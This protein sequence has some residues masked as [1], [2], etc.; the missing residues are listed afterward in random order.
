MKPDSDSG[1]N[2]CQ[3][4]VRVKTEIMNCKRGNVKA[5]KHDILTD[6]AESALPLCIHGGD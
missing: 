4:G 1:N 6:K 5:I 3:L 2:Q